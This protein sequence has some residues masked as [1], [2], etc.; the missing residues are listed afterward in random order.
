MT[1]GK[2]II[3]GYAIVLAILIVVSAVAFYTFRTVEGAYAEFLDVDTQAILI[4]ANLKLEARDQS[5]QYRGALL[6]PEDQNRLIEDMRQSHRQFDSLAKKLGALS[7]SEEARQI[8]QEIEDIQKRHKEA[9][10]GA[11]ALLQRGKRQ[12]AVG[13]STKEALPLATKL[14]DKCDQYIEFQQKR[15]AQGRAELSSTLSRSSLLLIVVSLL[16]I[17]SGIAIGFQLTRSITR[18]LREAISQL[19]TS[20]GEIVAMTTQVASGAT[21]TA[22]AVSETTTTVEEVKQTS[23]VASQKAKYVSDT[24]QRSAQVSKAGKASVDDTIEGMSNIKEQTDSIAQSIVSLSEQSQAIGEI[25]ATVSELAEQSNMLAVNAAIE[26]AKAGEQGKGFAV[27]AQ[28]VKSLAEQSKQAT[29]QVRAILSDIQKATHVAVMATE[30]GSKAVEAA[31]KQSNSTSEAIRGLTDSITEAA[32]AATQIAASS[33]QQLVGMDQVA[34][35]MEN[36][37]QASTQNVT[38]TKQAEQAAKNLNELG[39]RLRS[40]IE[41]N[42]AR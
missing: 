10:E 19:S 26:A 20:S 32:Q 24:A 12:E 34:L 17:A 28:E 14:R 41:V 6:Y 21:E 13:L 3:G 2:K 25:I 18:Q 9:Q 4:A 39:H 37:K 36:I 23:Q 35:A 5:A 42:G 38:A 22:T 7:R 8:L 27:V 40:L 16:G 33:Q 30:Q 31:V 11:V 1:I 29:V 15:L